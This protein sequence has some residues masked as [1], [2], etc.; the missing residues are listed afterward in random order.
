[1]TESSARRTQ[2]SEHQTHRITAPPCKAERQY[3]LTLQ[4]S[5]YCLSALRSTPAPHTGVWNI[6]EWDAAG[7]PLP[8]GLETIPPGSC[9][10]RYLL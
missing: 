9:A 1:M 7:S 10:I 5:R 3:L 6:H 4:V 2:S 8:L